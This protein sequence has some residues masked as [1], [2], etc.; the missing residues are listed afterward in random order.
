MSGSSSNDW[1]VFGFRDP[2]SSSDVLSVPKP[3]QT[4]FPMLLTT[5]TSSSCELSRE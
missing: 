5:Y 2:D 4:S 3:I 1:E